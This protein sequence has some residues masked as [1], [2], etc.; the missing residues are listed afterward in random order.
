MAG[1]PPLRVR[2]LPLGPAS[3][4]VHLLRAEQPGGE[5]FQRADGRD[6][7]V[8]AYLGVLAG[9]TG[10][11]L[12]RV[13]IE[14]P[15][16]DAGEPSFP[17]EEIPAN[18][19]IEAE[20][21]AAHSDLKRLLAAPAQFPELLAPGEPALLPPTI[22]CATS[23]RLFRIPCP[24]C[25][26]PLSTCRDDALLA[27]A[28]LPLYSAT[29][30]KFLYCSACHPKEGGEGA[31]FWAGTEAEARG[32]ER[33]D[34]L[35]DLRRDYGAALEKA[36]AENVSLK[37]DEL[38]QAS[39]APATTAGRKGAAPT[40][41]ESGWTVFNLH[42]SPF[43]VTRQAPVAFD[44]FVARLG[45]GG[46]TAEGA[47]A[48]PGFLF[49]AEG[50]G[51][52]AVEVLA[53]KLAA[54]L[55]IVADVRRHYLLLGRPHLDLHPDHLVVEPAPQGGFLPALWSFRVKLL[56]ASPSR[57]AHLGA[58]LAVPLP[59][60]DPRPPFAS[61]AIRA[62]R[63]ASPAA[64]EL[65]IERVLPE[66]GGADR[67]RIEG[68]LLD[69]HGFYPPPTLR[70]FVQLAWPRELFG[71]VRTA[72]ARLD[73][74]S[75][76]ESVEMAITTEPLELDVTLAQRL[77]RPG[78]F[79]V[80][81]VR[82]KIY[83]SLSAP[84][85]IYSLGI[86]LLRILLVNDTQALSTLEPLIEAVPQ[87]TSQSVRGSRRTVEE[88]L[89][90]MLAAEPERLAKANLFHRE[91]D[92]GPGRPN[93]IP[94]EIWTGVLLFALRLIGRGPGFG[95][96]PEK[97]GSY[98]FNEANPVAHLDEVQAE[99]EDLLRR[100]HGILFNRQA[101][102]V[103]VQTLISELLAEDVGTER[104]DKERMPTDRMKA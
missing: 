80:P 96:T 20:W 24:R 19:A 62:A 41:P 93:S 95:L 79:R 25:F 17:E 18:A 100:L 54:F 90:A 77:S 102:H 22:F 3:F 15:G 36:S 6:A 7:G 103:E 28:G 55:Q 81:G 101:V 44:E 46:E 16:D 34:S 23:G 104:K 73:P 64:G 61:P 50:S 21:A 42:D 32:L 58:G 71:R 76:P 68:T 52:D 70:D 4:A 97:G 67:W 37:L 99:A 98:G 74:R 29:A 83:S 49:A 33:V 56:G 27:A 35:E 11:V 63:L 8:R 57:L 85:D 13:V 53:L 43:L 39:A 30:A 59:P 47:E 9:E 65:M 84:E 91:T 69:P 1:P 51:I 88:A 60:R 40:N 14:L 12:D 75:A 38:P 89:S 2:L 78:G 92:R 5:P 31:R 26:G 87:G 82:Y 66:K 10:A 86:L 45:A 72:T 94:E 48:A